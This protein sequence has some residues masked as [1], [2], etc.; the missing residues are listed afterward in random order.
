MSGFENAQKN[1]QLINRSLTYSRNMLNI[2]RQQIDIVNCKKR[3]KKV[4][5]VSKNCINLATLSL[6][7]SLSL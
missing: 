7:E 4:G 1:Q 6:W 5:L 2:T 3:G